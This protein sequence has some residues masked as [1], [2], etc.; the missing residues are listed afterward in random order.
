M[1]VTEHQMVFAE[2]KSII[3]QNED[4]NPL[5]IPTD[6]VSMKIASVICNDPVAKQLK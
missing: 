6:Q 2:R 4:D 3:C 1:S 5:S